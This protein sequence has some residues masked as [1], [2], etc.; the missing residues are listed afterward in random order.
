[1]EVEHLILSIQR[2]S[3]EEY[4]KNIRKLNL[5]PIQGD[6]YQNAKRKMVSSASGNMPVNKELLI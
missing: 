3:F 5:I 4:E 2:Y 6:Y 1:M